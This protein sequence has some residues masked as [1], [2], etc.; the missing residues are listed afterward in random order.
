MHTWALWQRAEGQLSFSP[1]LR[2]RVGQKGAEVG[3]KIREMSETLSVNKYSQ[4][5]MTEQGELCFSV[6]SLL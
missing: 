3:R 2:K 1:S 6:L 4:L 5:I